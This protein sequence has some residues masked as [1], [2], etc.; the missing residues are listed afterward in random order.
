MNKRFVIGFSL[1]VTASLFSGCNS[2]TQNTQVQDVVEL[3]WQADGN[4]IYG[5]LQS[6]TATNTSVNPSAGYTIVRFNSDGSLAE[7]YNLDPKSR[8]RDLVT[9]SLDSYTPSLFVSSDASTIVTQLD[10]DLYRYHPKSGILEKL[11]T[12][13]HLIVASPDLHYAIGTPSLDPQVIKTIIIYDLSASP[14]RIVHQ[15]D[16]K[17]VAASSGIWLNN[18]LFGITCNDSVGAHISIFDTTSSG[19]PL[20]VIGGAEIAFHNAVFDS[21]TNELFFRNHGGKATDYFVDKVNLTT[22]SRGNILNFKVENFDVTRDESAIIYS[23]YDAS[24]TIHMKT[25]NLQS[26]NELAIADDIRLIIALSP[27]EDKLAYIRQR[28]QNFNEVRVLAFTKP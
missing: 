2:G 8:P 9:G 19:T 14:V 22:F 6:Y 17:G 1:Y 24:S 16:I 11:V 26:S 3:K 23:A 4:S 21:L 25:R 10:A 13:F 27:K 28:D 20:S 15:F 18:G 12:Q 5:F 7:T